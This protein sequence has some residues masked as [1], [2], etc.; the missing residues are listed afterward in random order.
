ME[1]R[2]RDINIVTTLISPSVIL[3]AISDNSRLLSTCTHYK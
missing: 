3:M 2:Y 1:G